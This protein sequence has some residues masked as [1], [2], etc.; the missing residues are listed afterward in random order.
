M[1][2]GGGTASGIIEHLTREYPLI[3]LGCLITP[4]NAALKQVGRMA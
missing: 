4:E 2:E 3:K 1:L